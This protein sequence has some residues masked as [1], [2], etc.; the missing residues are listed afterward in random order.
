M[1]RRVI[2]SR[3][4]G[5]E[6]LESSADLTFEWSV[7]SFDATRRLGMR[8]CEGKTAGVVIDDVIITVTKLLFFYSRF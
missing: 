8:I 1:A 7:T 5:D 6:H 2:A 3:S 4:S